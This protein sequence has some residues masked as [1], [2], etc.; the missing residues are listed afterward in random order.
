MELWKSLRTLEETVD[1]TLPDPEGDLVVRHRHTGGVFRVFQPFHREG[2][3]YLG[4]ASLELAADEVKPAPHRWSQ[5]L[6][7]ALDQA[8]P[9]YPLEVPPAGLPTTPTST[10]DKQELT[11]WIEP[12]D[13]VIS[14]SLR[15]EPVFPLREHL[16]LTK[17]MVQYRDSFG[18]E[19]DELRYEASMEVL[20]VSRKSPESHPFSAQLR[21][22]EFAPEV[23][24]GFLREQARL[25]CAAQE[26]RPWVPSGPFLIL[27]RGQAL[28]GVMDFL[29]NQLGAEALAAGTSTLRVHAP[30]WETPAAE[31]LTVTS[32]GQLYNSPEQ[33]GFDDEGIVLHH[34]SLVKD[35]TVRGFWSTQSTAHWLGL[36]LTGRPRNFSVSPGTR[37]WKDLSGERILEVHRLRW[38]QSEA[39]T[40]D[41]WAEVGLADLHE[42]GHRSPV[43]GFTLKGN[44]REVLTN[45]QFSSDVGTWEHYEGPE[46]LVVSSVFIGSV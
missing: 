4:S 5:A 37:T 46:F 33:G 14:Q 45:A 17:R 7:Q 28:A 44:W 15:G 6:S 2:R 22:S 18:K 9:W 35:G 20:M 23:I 16:R 34:H 36:P 12:L 13:E 30:L 40:G 43:F 27:L 19:L 3:P 1:A 24:G 32:L 41:F 26:A 42:N 10:L 11:R 39:A 8:D 29:M 38:A 25:T 21:F 31:P